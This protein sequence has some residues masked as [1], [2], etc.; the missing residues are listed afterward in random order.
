[1]SEKFGFDNLDAENFDVHCFSTSFFSN[2]STE[3]EEKT[4]N[5]KTEKDDNSIEKRLVSRIGKAVK[6]NEKNGVKVFNKGLILMPIHMKK[7]HWSL[8][9]LIN[10]NLDP[11]K[12]LSFVVHLDSMR[13]AHNSDRIQEVLYKWLN[14][15]RC[16]DLKQGACYNEETLP[17]F[18]DLNGESFFSL[19]RYCHYVLLEL[20]KCF[21]CNLFSLNHDIV[22][23]QA[24]G[25]SVD[26]GVFVCQFTE[27]LLE[28]IFRHP[29]AHFGSIKELKNV[30]N[31][32]I[33]F[34]QQDVTSLRKDDLYKLVSSF[35]KDNSHRVQK[36]RT[37][38]EEEG[39]KS[40]TPIKIDQDDGEDG[41]AGEDGG[42]GDNAING[43]DGHNDSFG[44]PGSIDDDSEV[45]QD[46]GEDGDDGDNDSDNDGR[47]NDSSDNDGSDNDSDNLDGGSGKSF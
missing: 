29:L 35:R 17:M 3:Y 26:C 9:A 14:I 1:M 13:G 36:G 19:A 27:C 31:N 42:V 34:N 4:Y 12:G 7:N 47:D 10:L 6:C 44:N 33:Q 32:S 18:D 5:N 2:M 41:D 38:G 15:Q 28:L 22:P 46:D 20:L 16:A 40:D 25:N 21:W 45:D 11:E 8:I 23:Q 30:I 43:I 37:F 39:N 24:P